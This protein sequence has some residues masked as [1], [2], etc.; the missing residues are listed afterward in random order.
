MIKYDFTNLA[1]AISRLKNKF[2][3]N[4][5]DLKTI[6]N[7]L[8]KFFTDSECKE[9]LY[10]TNIDRMFFGIKVMPI[11][12]VSSIYDLISDD[13]PYRINTYMIEFDSKLFDPILNL[14]I[15]KIIF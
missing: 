12:N 13:D 3:I 8:N 6:K 4:T 9:V 11:I 14:D 10:T 15:E 2:D 1:D 7:E 5:S